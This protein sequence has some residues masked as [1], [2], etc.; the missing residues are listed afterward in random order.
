MRAPGTKGPSASCPVP[1]SAWRRSLSFC[2]ARLGASAARLPGTP[3]LWI[4]LHT[5]HSP[6]TSC[7]G[8]L[9][10]AP[11]PRNPG[12]FSNATGCSLASPT[13]PVRLGSGRG[14]GVG[15]G[16]G[17]ERGAHKAGLT[18][19]SPP[20]PSA[21]Q[22]A[23]SEP[24]GGINNPSIPLPARLPPKGRPLP[25]KVHPRADDSAGHRPHPD[26]ASAAARRGGQGLGRLDLN[27]LS[28][29]GYLQPYYSL[30]LPLRTRQPPP[31]PPPQ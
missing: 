13:G 10:R 14:P 2:L 18:P 23:I 8:F 27:L 29:T 21:K 30:L 25:P 24:T 22:P 6:M 1:G 28:L 4:F 12:L 31:S 16:R 5:H 20:P 19:E 9:S 26:P 11:S 7:Y 17:K 15:S 3:S